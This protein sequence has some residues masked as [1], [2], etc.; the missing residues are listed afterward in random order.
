MSKRY[1]LTDELRKQVIRVYTEKKMGLSVIEKMKICSIDLARQ[2]LVDAGIPLRSHGRVWKEI[3]DKKFEHR[4][5]ET[6]ETVRN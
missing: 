1:E 4:R 6:K 3:E 5:Y 2:I